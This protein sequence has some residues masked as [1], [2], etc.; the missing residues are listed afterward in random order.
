MQSVENTV[1]RRALLHGAAALPLGAAVAAVPA[2]A[3]EHADAELIALGREFE[4]RAAHA[5]KLWGALSQ[6]ASQEA[7]DAALG[8][9]DALVKRIAQSPARTLAGF[10]VKA[11]TIR[12][13]GR[14]RWDNPESADYV[15]L[16]EARLID[17]ILAAAG[18]ASLT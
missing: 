13:A 7:A 15:E 12:W 14:D 6:G 11:R 10:A 9:A 1:S 3:A 2:A 16:A 17:D 18:E 5:D 8:A 4:A